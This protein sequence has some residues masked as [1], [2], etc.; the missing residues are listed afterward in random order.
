[1]PK[2]SP[3]RAA[4]RN[5]QRQLFRHRREA[6]C[7][8]QQSSQAINARIQELFY[9]G[10]FSIKDQRPLISQRDDF[11]PK[12]ADEGLQSGPLLLLHGTMQTVT[13]TEPSHARRALIGIDQEQRLVIA[14]ADSLLGGLHRPELQEIFLSRAVADPGHGFIES[15]RRRP[16]AALCQSGQVRGAGGRNLRGPGR[17]RLFQPA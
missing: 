9:S 3:R 2:R 11:L 10:I 1:M 4:P 14:V 13:G 5:D 12:Q 8:P 15:R 17:H 16:R 6:S 7:V